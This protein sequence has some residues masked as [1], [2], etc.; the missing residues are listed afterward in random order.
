MSG[1]HSSS[2]Y[3]YNT[4]T[5]SLM[6]HIHTGRLYLVAGSN[7]TASWRS[8][9]DTV[10]YVA[11]RAICVWAARARPGP[12]PTAAAARATKWTVRVDGRTDGR[13]DPTTGRGTRCDVFAAISTSRVL[14]FCDNVVEPR[15]IYRSTFSGSSDRRT[16][17]RRRRRENASL[18]F[19]R[20]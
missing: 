20:A 15:R 3:T 10:A 5:C 7:N 11:R 9:R 18:F 14:S 17:L 4:G 12:L 19:T 16:R 13:T 2:I 8:R 6:V 1:F